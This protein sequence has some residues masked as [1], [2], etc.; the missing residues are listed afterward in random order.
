M[1]FLTLSYQPRANSEMLSHLQQR[2]AHKWSRYFFT[3]LN[4]NSQVALQKSLGLF[5]KSLGTWNPEKEEKTHI[6]LW[7]E[8]LSAALS[9]LLTYMVW[10]MQQS[11]AKIDD[12]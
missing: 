3:L 2:G 8:I 6:R 1:G 11:R 4:D 9:V 12:L 5:R 10:H 7:E